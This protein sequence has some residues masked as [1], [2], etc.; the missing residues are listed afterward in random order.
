M[1]EKQEIVWVVLR[2]REAMTENDFTP[3]DNWPVKVFDDRADARAY[4]KRMNTTSRKY[5]FLVHRCKKG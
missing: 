5:A 4:A 3:G 2:Y 1:A